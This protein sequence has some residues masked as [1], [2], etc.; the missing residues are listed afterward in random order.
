MGHNGGFG[1]IY[2]ALLLGEGSQALKADPRFV[3][4]GY[5]VV[6]YRGADYPNCH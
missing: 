3:S 2:I 1:R 5:L 6:E 4:L